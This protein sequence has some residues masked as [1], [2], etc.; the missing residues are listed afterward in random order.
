MNTLQ[1]RHLI[2]LGLALGIAISGVHAQEKTDPYKKADAKP[3][4]QAEAPKITKPEPLIQINAEWVELKTEDA[5]PLLREGL[6]PN[7][8]EFIGKIRNLEKQG[9]ATV[10]ETISAVT[11]SGQRVSTGGEKEFIYPTD[12][13]PVDPPKLKELNLSGNQLKEQRLVIAAEAPS[14]SLP[15]QFTMRALGARMEVDPVLSPDGDIVDLNI[16]PELTLFAGNQAHGI[17]RVGGENVA[18]LEQP[19]FVSSKIQTALTLRTG[20]TVLA[21]VT[22]AH[23]AEG[24]IDRTKKWFILIHVVVFPVN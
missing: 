3:G 22:P 23:T 5:M 7:N 4:A 14:S 12:F 1:P 8:A 6:A 18:A 13:A 9:K 19:N 21:G 16:N 11:R 2:T 20:D 10:I 15:S 17:V 24:E